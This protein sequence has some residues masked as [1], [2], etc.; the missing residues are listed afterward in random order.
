ME[1]AQNTEAAAP[2][3]A[4]A[5]PKEKKPR[6]MKKMK[7]EDFIVNAVKAGE[8]DALKIAS[9]LEDAASKGDISMKK[10]HKVAPTPLMWFLQVKWYFH[11]AKKKG[12]VDGD[13][14][15][16]P[17]ERK[18]R[19]KKEAAAAPADAAGS[20]ADAPASSENVAAPATEAPAEEALGTL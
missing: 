2:T 12:L 18:P 20:T 1:N 15:V 17:R 6:K 14:I 16:P 9:L 4:A 13:L 7:R 11:Q 19:K 3:E 8:R 10:N 5:A